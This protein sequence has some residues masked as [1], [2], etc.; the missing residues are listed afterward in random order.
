MSGIKNIGN[1]PNVNAEVQNNRTI[2][3]TPNRANAAAAFDKRL[4]E[5]RSAKSKAEGER[6]A[7]ARRDANTN[8]QQ[9]DAEILRQRT[10]EELKTLVQAIQTGVT[11]SWELTDLIFFARHPEMQGEPLTH[12]HQ[13]LLDEWN[14][15]SALLVH[16]TI[17]EVSDFLGMN[18][19][20]MPSGAE[21]SAGTIQDAFARATMKPVNSTA[22]VGGIEGAAGLDG[23]SHIKG[24]GGTKTG[25]YDEIIAR[26]VEWCPGLS[27]AIL[28]GLLAQE[29]NFNPTVIN[30]YG[31]AGIAQFGRP[32]AREVGLNVGIAGTAS[33]ERLDPTKAIPAASRLLRIKAQ[34]LGEISFSRYGQPNGVEFWKFVLAAYNGGEGTVALAQGHAYRLGLSQARDKGLV[35]TDAVSFARNYASKWENLKLGGANSPLGLAAARFFPKIAEAKYHEIGDYPTSIVARARA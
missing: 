21:R 33:D 5:T 10:L 32:A 2:Q 22:G 9:S 6:T 35:G 19:A 8:L 14:D 23:L 1:N 15:I 31:Y 11:D 7:L 26:A 18:V 29:S 16:P 3:P 13:A 4:N 30:H 24:Y 27:P 25:R 28:K 17:N 20:G 34:R 12:E